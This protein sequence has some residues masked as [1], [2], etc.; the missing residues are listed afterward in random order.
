MRCVS[1]SFADKVD[2][3]RLDRT[4]KLKGFRTERFPHALQV[5]DKTRQILCHFFANGSLVV[6]SRTRVDCEP[7]L[8]MAYAYCDN[9]AQIRVKDSFCFRLGDTISM[10]PHEYFNTEVLTIDE[11]EDRVQL[12]FAFAFSQSIKLKH[13]EQVLESLISRYSP[14][15]MQ[16]ASQGKVAISRKRIHQVI[17]QIVNTK[18]QINLSSDFFY[19]PKF[20]WQC[21]GLE[22]NYLLVHK[23]LDVEERI[24][25]INQKINTLNET[26]TIFNSYLETRHA[27]FLEVIII[28]LIAI[29]IIF[30][31]LNIHF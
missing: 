27:H 24:S 10:E 9:I 7:L 20:F 19:P 14:L 25:A 30:S 2:L 6:W 17:A 31:I 15:I 21:P 23:Y 13:F 12:S 22:P 8:D 29:E 1:Y 16:L 5:L 28:V 11:I 4:V 18:S 3:V 26:F